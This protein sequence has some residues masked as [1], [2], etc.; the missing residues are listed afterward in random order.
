MV[1]EK[2]PD[3]KRKVKLSRSKQQKNGASVK[4]RE[5]PVE[6]RENPVEERENPIQEWK[7]PLKEREDPVEEREDPVLEA[8]L[9]EK[10]Q[11]DA[12]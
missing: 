2:S 10:V 7:D 9:Q 3:L 4:E 8:G 12:S 11:D 5:N 6:E 1:I